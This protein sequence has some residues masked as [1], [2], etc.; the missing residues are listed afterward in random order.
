M[1]TNGDSLARGFGCFLVIAGCACAAI[2]GLAVWLVPLAWNWIKP[3]IH[4]VTA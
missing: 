4:Q 3:L 1:W 2:G